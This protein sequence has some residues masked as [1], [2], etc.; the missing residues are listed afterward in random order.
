[1]WDIFAF[2]FRIFRG[3]FCREVTIKKDEKCPHSEIL[4]FQRYSVF[5]PNAGKYRLEKLWTWTL[6]TQCLTSRIICYPV[7]IKV[8]F[9]TESV[10]QQFKIKKVKHLVKYRNF[11]LYPGVEILW[12]RTVSTEF[13]VIRPK[14]CKNCVFPKHFEKRKLGKVVVFYEAKDLSLS[15]SGN[16]VDI[17]KCL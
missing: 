9:L 12:K 15:Y 16:L 2:C 7:D 11:T 17:P 1:M 4:R 6:F 13:R 8:Y 10:W 14:L 3:I 5:S